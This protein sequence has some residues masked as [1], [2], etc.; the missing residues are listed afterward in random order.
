MRRP[1]WPKYRV[2]VNAKETPVR[3]EQFETLYKG[4]KNG[5]TQQWTISVSDATITKVYGQVNGTLQTTTDVILK[6]KNVGRAN[7][8][9]PITQA[10]AEAQSQWEK[11]LKSGYV[12]VLSDAQT[13]KV[14]TQFIEGGIKVMLAQ[15][16]SQHGSKIQYPAY[17]QPKLDGVRCV[18][19]LEKG[20]CTLWTR[21]RKPITGVPHIIRAIEQQFLY[22]ERVTTCRSWP[23][24]PGSLVLDGELYRHTYRD[25]FEKIVSFV[26]QSVPKAGHECVEY[27]VYDVVEDASFAARTWAVDELNLKS[28]LVAVRT[29]CVTSIDDVMGVDKEHRAAG[30]EGTIVRSAEGKY[31]AGRSMGLQKLKQFDDAEFEVTGVQPGRGRMSECAI[32][33]CVTLTGA[34]F[35]CKM[36]G[37]LET[38]KSYLVTPDHAVGKQLTVRYQGLTNGGVPR[39]PIGVSVRDYE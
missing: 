29:Q 24:R 2:I 17:V 34:A 32:F 30:Y 14:D 20:V 16:F 31:E 13:G 37:A 5:S 38:L 1:Y 33:T 10:R 9:T 6:G 7:A 18:A 12:R 35:S 11:K 28:P 23:G 26:R 36:E 39:F 22:G 8:T 3:S 19:I 15:K 25:K 21:T 27:H 4:N